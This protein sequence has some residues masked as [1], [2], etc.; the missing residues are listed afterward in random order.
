LGKVS[1]F[2]TPVSPG[3]GPLGLE[4]F[5]PEEDWLEPELGD[6]LELEELDELFEVMEELEETF[7]EEF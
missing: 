6:R 2:Q 3:A 1:R 7:W 4:L 5:E